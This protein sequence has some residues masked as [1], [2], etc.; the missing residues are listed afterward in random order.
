MKKLIR[1]V[2]GGVLDWLMPDRVALREVRFKFNAEKL[3]VWLLGHQLDAVRENALAQVNK[4]CQEQDALRLQATRLETEVVARR[5]CNEALAQDAARVTRDL[6]RA[7]ARR[8][9][10]DVYWRERLTRMQA[11]M[12]QWQ[13]A[14]RDAA[15]ARVEYR[16]RLDLALT[17][18]PAKQRKAYDN[19]LRR[20][21]EAAGALAPVAGSLLRS[22]LKSQPYTWAGI[23]R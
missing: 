6:E 5:N 23:N 18:M 9:E 8:Q 12:A 14:H 11:N 15:T 1:R 20:E 2:T 10:R 3:T 21:A 13:K 16:K 4:F 22:P 17:L 7:N 19:T